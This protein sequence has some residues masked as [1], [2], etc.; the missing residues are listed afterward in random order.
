MSQRQQVRVVCSPASTAECCKD[1]PEQAGTAWYR[2]L[3]LRAVQLPEAA[4]LLYI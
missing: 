2:G 3:W 4:R 1:R